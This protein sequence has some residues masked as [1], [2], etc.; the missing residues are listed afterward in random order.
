MTA[1]APTFRSVE[2]RT[3]EIAEGAPPLPPTADQMAALR[4]DLAKVTEERDEARA[5][6]DNLTLWLKDSGSQVANLS[7]GVAMYQAERDDY[8]ERADEYRD[9]HLEAQTR[10]QELEAELEQAKRATTGVRP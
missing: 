6:V 5:E 3:G 8:R 4:A 2:Q 1:A 9:M 10:I 7:S